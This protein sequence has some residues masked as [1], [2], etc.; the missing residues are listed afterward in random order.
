[1]TSSS[2]R[3]SRVPSAA[4]QQQHQYQ[5]AMLALQRQQQQL[6]SNAVLNFVP[7]PEV[8]AFQVMPS[9]VSRISAD[10]PIY[11]VDN[12]VEYTPKVS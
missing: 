6:Q 12:Q 7:T 2:T 1:M 8:P 3:L 10:Q 11:Q 4:D 9:S 5:Q